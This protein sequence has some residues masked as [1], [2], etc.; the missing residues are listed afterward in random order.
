MRYL[1]DEPIQMKADLN[2]DFT[3]LRLVSYVPIISCADAGCGVDCEEQMEARRLMGFR[4][5]WWS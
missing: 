2:F 3:K 1:F 4:V 5:I